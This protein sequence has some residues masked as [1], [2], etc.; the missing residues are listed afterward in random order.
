M[1]TTDPLVDREFGVIRFATWN[2]REGRQISHPMEFE[3]SSMV[4]N[5]ALLKEYQVDIIA[6]QEVDNPATTSRVLKIIEARTDLKHIASMR[7]SRS[8]FEGDESAGVA[9]ASRFPFQ[10]TH[11]ELLPNPKLPITWNGGE[12]ISHDKGLLTCVMNVNDIR[13][14]FISIHVFPFHRFGRDAGDAELTNV[15]QKV[16]TCTNA[17]GGPVVLAGDFNTQDR[18]LV[19]GVA[20]GD[21]SSA[22]KGVATHNGKETDDILFSRHFEMLGDPQAV[23]NFSDH[24]LCIVS[25]RLN[26]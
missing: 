15:W 8:S 9:I 3:D 2:V 11:Q 18:L 21:M 20:R 4:E 17:P 1:R 13:I 22:F 23:V 14:C 25:L 12:S 7:L 19:S 5:V 10:Y 6:L 26:V 16:S 24:H